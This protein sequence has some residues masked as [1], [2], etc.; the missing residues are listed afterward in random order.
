MTL[1]MRTLSWRGR[2]P[3]LVR[4]AAA[5]CVL[6]AGS[7]PSVFAQ[8]PPAQRPAGRS[9]PFVIR[10][11]QIRYEQEHPWNPDAAGLR[12]ATLRVGVSN[13]VF[14][15]PEGGGATRSFSLSELEEVPDARF[16]E[17]AIQSVSEAVRDAIVA[18]GLMG[19][20]V[21]PDPSQLRVVDGHVMDLR[22]P[23]DTSLTL[24][25]TIG[26]VTQMRTVGLGDRLPVDA[27]VNNPLH[28]RILARS[29]IRPS[30]EGDAERADLVRRD[31]LDDY[32]YRLNR[33]PGR[34]VDFAVAADEENAGGVLLDY[35]VTENRPWLVFAQGSTTGSA[36][37]SKWRE[38][39]GFIHNQLTNNDDI[40][41][42]GYVTADFEDVNLAYG[43]YER[44][45]PWS[46]RVRWRVGGTWY[47]YVSSEFGL[48]DEAFSGDGWDASAEVSWNF[49]QHHQLFLDAVGGVK[50]EHV[51]ARNGIA[52]VEG[53]DDFFK[54]S[55]ALRLERNTEVARTFAQVALEANVPGVAG[56]SSDLDALGRFGADNDWWTLRA[57]AN[58][59]FYLD[60][61]LFDS[62]EHKA[63]LVN[64]LAISFDG[65]LSMGNRLIP[66]ETM[67][68]GGLYT[69]RGY[70]ESRVAGDNA[71][72]ASAEYRFHVSQALEPDVTPSSVFGEPFRFR[73]QYQYGPTDW[74][75][76][77]K[78]FVD[79]GR[80]TNT[81][82]QAF[83]SDSTLLGVGIGAELSVTRHLSVRADW[84][85]ALLDVEDATGG[86]TV[87]A[88][89]NELYIV[90][91]GVF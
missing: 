12:G 24:I 40:L 88:G 53:Q 46:D 78:A 11:V 87:D 27:T 2:F 41:K 79:L 16:D 64:E 39:F 82:R 20:Y 74:D 89:R 80:V 14:V 22:A 17:T 47:E 25:V 60:P 33:H 69:V 66:N 71:F 7:I 67:P 31:R 51:S 42:L 81:N 63:G 76:R 50:F 48:A 49:F 13:G 32:G 56:T 5:A 61:L 9:G 75:L 28:E 59:S 57:S 72:V 1:F 30:R 45:A 86:K 35:L 15:A 26:R 85:V 10:S 21:T 23:G 68:V 29:P 84:G 65:Q 43:S 38:H 70:P 77:L 3:D 52:Q 54:P 36:G 8:E 18:R 62:P 73:P 37:T 58:H 6:G 4:C 55:L 34:R 91:T 90:I 19:V 44:P 83:E